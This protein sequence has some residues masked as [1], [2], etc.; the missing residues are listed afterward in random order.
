MFFA[1]IFSMSLPFGEDRRGFKNAISGSLL[2]LP[3]IN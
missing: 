2:L 1:S 3:I